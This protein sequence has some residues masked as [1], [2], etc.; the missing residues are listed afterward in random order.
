MKPLPLAALLPLE[1][2]IAVFSGAIL[3][4]L[5]PPLNLHPLQW[6]AY[7]PMMVMLLWRPRPK[8][9]FRAWIGHRH[10]WLA[11][12][13]GVVAQAAIFWWVIET[14]TTFSNIP[15][16]AAVGILGL[17]SL[18]FGMPYTIMWWVLPSLRRFFGTWWV[19]AL[20]AA[21][22]V[23][24][25]LGTWII[26]FPYNQGVAQYRVLPT[27]QIVGITG[28]WGVTFLV[29]F[30][31]AALAEL[32]LSL[33]EGRRQGWLWVATAAGLWGL[34]NTYGVVRLH[35]IDRIL[36][37]APSVRVFQVQDHVEM[38]DRK[39]AYPCEIW[40]FWYG[41][42]DAL[43]PGEVDLVVWPEGGGVYPLNLPRRPMRY[44]D[45]PCEDI[46]NPLE[47]LQAL[48]QRLDAELLV[49][50]TAIEFYERPDGGRDRRS[51]NS[52]YHIPPGG[53]VAR[54]D[55]II[56]LPFGEYIPLSD[57]F[58]ALRDLIEGPGNFQAGTEPVVFEGKVRLSTPICYE[59]ILP[60]LCRRFDDPELL[61]NGTLDTWFGDTAAP[62]QHAML[63]SIRAVELGRPLVRSAYTGISMVVEPS[64]RIY[65]ETAPYEKIARV[66][67]VKVADAP[68][69]Y[70]RLSAVGLQDWFVWLCLIGLVGGRLIEPWMRRERA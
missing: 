66:V 18:V 38:L 50:S 9:G 15:W 64:G 41:E 49:G 58:P 70:R 44:R 30:V 33:R 52:V 3:A 24:E 35:Q 23:I 57:T 22:V 48:A 55:K 20:P 34:V 60:H 5:A 8:G 62:H 21:A 4:V 47:K 17:F 51:L 37:Q 53:E 12:V 1:L 61:I 7:A 14:I 67:T 54:Y 69:L 36:A 40:N 31:N 2:L 25:W 16:L 28:I 10:T 6:V 32:V 68:T 19:L 29:L 42:T 63:A 46:G 65:A 11:L 59:A 27:F 56:P 39:R 26:L 45:A 13:A 43:Q